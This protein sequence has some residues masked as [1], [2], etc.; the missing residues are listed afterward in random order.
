MITKTMTVSSSVYVFCTGLFGKDEL[1]TSFPV[2]QLN[3]RFDIQ[4]MS[5]NN[6]YNMYQFFTA[7]SFSYLII[8]LAQVFICKLNY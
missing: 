2:E 4:V 1:Y 3:N 7:L 8:Q 6:L 5:T